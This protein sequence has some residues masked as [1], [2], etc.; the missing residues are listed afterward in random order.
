MLKKHVTKLGQKN[1][2]YAKWD[3][4]SSRPTTTLEICQQRTIRSLKTGSYQGQIKDHKILLFVE[5]QKQKKT[6]L[7]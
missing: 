1:L 6:L 2:C 7:K 3:D 5:K 4:S